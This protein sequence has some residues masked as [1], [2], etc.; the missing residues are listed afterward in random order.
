MQGTSQ[1]IA[2]TTAACRP[3]AAQG[4]SRDAAGITAPASLPAAP[5]T[6][7]PGDTISCTA[8]YTVTQADTDA[9]SFTNT[10]TVA[11]LDP[12]NNPV[13]DG[14]SATVDTLRVGAA[15]LTKDAAPDTGV[16]FH[17]T[18]LGPG[19]PDPDVA[20]RPGKGERGR[21]Q[22]RL[23]RV[24][25]HE[26]AGPAGRVDQHGVAAVTLLGGR[27]GQRRR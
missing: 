17:R 22:E 12:S 18:D 25:Q 2:L 15:T 8:T 10:A 5:A 13:S 1:S 24:R 19:A 26:P 11:G 6:L 14:D 23:D 9:G 16:V 7:A 3:R 4:P 21:A 27:V 20:A